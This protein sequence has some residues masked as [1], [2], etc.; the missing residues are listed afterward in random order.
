MASNNRFPPRPLNKKSVFDR[1]RAEAEAK[2]QREAAETAAIYEDF[3]K[4]FDDGG[5]ERDSA[6]SSHDMPGKGGRLSGS[7]AGAVPSLLQPPALLGSGRRHFSMPTSGAAAMRNSG[8]GSLGPTTSS[9]SA[10]G[11]ESAAVPSRRGPGGGRLAAFDD[12]SDEEDGL[13]SSTTTTTAAAAASASTVTA[14]GSIGSSS[15]VST[16]ADR[17]EERATS[18]PTIRLASLPPNMSPAAVRAL[19]SP[20]GLVV[21]G[22]LM[23]PAATTASGSTERKSAAAIVTLAASSAASDIDAAVSALQ[24]RYLGYGYYLNLH[25]HLS[26]AVAAA[27]AAVSLSTLSTTSSASQPFGAKPV[28]PARLDGAEFTNHAS[29][30]TYG[31]GRIG[32]PPP[33]MFAPP[34]SGNG[35][36]SS[37]VSRDSL[38]Y[39]PVRPPRDI[40]KLRMIHRVVEK[41]LS[42]GPAFEA[43]LMSR[44]EVQREERWAWI[45]DARSE[46]GVWYRYRLWETVTGH[47]TKRGHGRYMPLFEGSHAWK[48]PDDPLPYEF[49]TG[50]AEFVSDSEYGNSSDDSDYDDGPRGR[51]MDAT[52]TT[53]GGGSGSA[54]GTGAAVAAAVDGDEDMFLNPIE[55]AKLAHLLARLPSTLSKL[56]KGDIARVTSFAIR[57]ASRGSNE[58]VDMIISNIE[59]PF[60]YTAANPAHHRADD[61]EGTSGA[62]GEPGAVRDTSGAKLVGVY[63]VSDILSSSATSGI[64]HAWRY[65]Q[66][67]DTALRSRRVFEGLGL[68]AERLHWG[69]LRADKWK[70]SIGLVLDHWDGWSVFSAETQEYLVGS[71]ENPPSAKKDK[72]AAADGASKKGGRW[73]TVDSA[74]A[75]PVEESGFQPA[76]EAHRGDEDG[77]GNDANDG[78]EGDD[79]DDNG[80]GDD[81]AYRSEYTDD[82]ELDLACLA[83]EDIDGEPMSDFDLDGIPL[84]ADEIEALIGTDVAAMSEEGEIGSDDDAAGMSGLSDG[85]GGG[86]GDSDVEMEAGDG[87]SCKENENDQGTV[88]VAT[89]AAVAAKPS[90]KRMRAVDMFADAD[91][92]DGE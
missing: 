33:A 74:A 10:A 14:M 32:I 77:D 21:E 18:K 11:A 16:A 39:V 28:P 54:V 66:L 15:L 69:R 85:G 36:S 57:H 89:A 56:R 7:A 48:I 38:L 51:G 67:F 24:N 31:R 47:Q 30:S 12:D 55:K 19:V 78:D 42:Q 90:R 4:S 8:P 73:K 3:V 86:G 80:E 92:D 63:V 2:R 9:G 65:R 87:E 40:R 79:D 76:A 1:Q 71:F 5:S 34:A 64:R 72:K 50:V 22:V 25:R 60:T 88:V 46:A 82:E 91:A 44:P 62:S 6:S 59:T 35:S 43:L 83:E 17:A 61:G 20:A 84:T 37:V 68:M 52:I 23:L 49:V 81:G 53:N 45:W 75:R 58:I 29:R 13:G 27:T 70:R 41:V 26:S